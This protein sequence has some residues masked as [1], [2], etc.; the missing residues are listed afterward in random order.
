MSRRSTYIVVAIVACA[1][2]I[3]GLIASSGGNSRPGAGFSDSLPPVPKT[4]V[5]L[6]REIGPFQFHG[7]TCNTVTNAVA[8]EAAMVR[9]NLASLANDSSGGTSCAVAWVFADRE[10]FAAMSV[11]LRLNMA[12]NVGATAIYG[13]DWIIALAGPA[14]HSVI[15]LIERRTGG[16]FGMVGPKV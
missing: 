16:T 7:M 1:A 2:V 9:A 13:P 6:M 15:K 10:S 12:L 4:A 5:A 11:G 3:A 14:P 8:T